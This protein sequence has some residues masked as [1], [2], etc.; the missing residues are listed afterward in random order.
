VDA[1]RSLFA[2]GIARAA[3]ASKVLASDVNPKRLAPPPGSRQ[4]SPNDVVVKNVPAA[5][6]GGELETAWD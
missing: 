6:T 1:G 3:G 4:R 2:V 5:E